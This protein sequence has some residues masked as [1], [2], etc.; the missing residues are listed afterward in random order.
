MNNN[1]YVKRSASIEFEQSKSSQS[2]HRSLIRCTT[3][4]LLLRKRDM[5]KMWNFYTGMRLGT[6]IDMVR[7]NKTINNITIV[8]IEHNVCD[9]T[10]IS[11]YTCTDVYAMFLL[12]W[13]QLASVVCAVCHAFISHES[14]FI[15]QLNHYLRL[16]HSNVYTGT[17]A[18]VVQ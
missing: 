14:F 3:V 2:A 15:R 10:E 8:C 5:E 18:A 1:K 9:F 6:G 7:H 12:L 13:A 17:P 11:I 16:F 4:V